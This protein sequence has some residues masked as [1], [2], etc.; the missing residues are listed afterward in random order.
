MG[1]DETPIFSQNNKLSSDK[2]AGFGQSLKGLQLRY[3]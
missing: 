3:G 1:S 2:R